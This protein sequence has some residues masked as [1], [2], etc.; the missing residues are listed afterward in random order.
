MDT[1]S[2]ATMSDGRRIIARAI[3]SRC[4]CPPDSMWGYFA[5]KSFTGRSRTSS[6][7][8][9]IRCSR[10]APVPNLLMS[11]GSSRILRTVMNGGSA[12]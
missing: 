7:T 5:R 4:C 6:M 12:P 2:S 10:S 3:T 11:I 9:R 8:S 1:G